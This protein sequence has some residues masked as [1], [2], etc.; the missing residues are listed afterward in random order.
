MQPRAGSFEAEAVKFEVKSCAQSLVA[1]RPHTSL[2]PAAP[3]EPGAPPASPEVS[4]PR[5]VELEMVSFPR[6]SIDAPQEVPNPL[7]YPVAEAKVAQKIAEYTNR[8][9]VHPFSAVPTDMLAADSKIELQLPDDAAVEGVPRLVAT[10]PK[11]AVCLVFLASIVSGAL[12]GL[13]GELSFSINT[14]LFSDQ[15]DPIVQQVDLHTNL[16]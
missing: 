9:I 15:A 2:V 5:P 14:S 11:L 7:E 8:P 16:R 3:V 6:M 10:R 12:L 4:S 13:A 1:V